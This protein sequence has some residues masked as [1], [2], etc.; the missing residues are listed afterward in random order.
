MRRLILAGFI[1]AALL[2]ISVLGIGLM[3]EALANGN[4]TIA[5]LANATGCMF[6][7]IITLFGP[8]SGTRFNPVVTLAFLL[9]GERVATTVIFLSYRR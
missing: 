7:C 8:I 5:L 3:G 1:G 4:M 6:Y 9:G 2:L